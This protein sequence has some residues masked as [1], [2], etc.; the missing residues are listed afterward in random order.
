[1]TSTMYQLWTGFVKSGDG[2]EWCII[3]SWLT[4]FE[5]LSV[6]RLHSD[7]ISSTEPRSHAFA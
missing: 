4:S 1:M 2:D 5:G 6:A 3:L 7:V